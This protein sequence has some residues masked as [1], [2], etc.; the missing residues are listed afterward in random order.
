VGGAVRAWGGRG[1]VVVLWWVIGLAVLL[2]W[3]TK[4]PQYTLI[5][6]VPLCLS[7]AEALRAGGRA[8]RARGILRVT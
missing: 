4:W 8:L 6:I 1:R 7:A 3:P 5:I 2:L